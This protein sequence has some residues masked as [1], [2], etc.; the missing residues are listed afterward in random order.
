MKP[1]FSILAILLT[2]FAVHGQDERKFPRG[3]KPTPAH[4][5]AAAMKAGAITI[6]KNI[7]APPQVVYVPKRLS[8]WGNS[9]YGDCVTAESCFA[10]AAYS[11]YVG[12]DEIFV[13]EADCIAWARSHG[14]LNGADLLTVIQDMEKDGIKDEKGSVRKAGAS[15]VVDYTVE[16]SLQSAIALGPVSIAIDANAL[17]SG[18]GNKSG[19]YAF[20]GGRFPNTDHCVSLCGYGPTSAL[21][22]ALGAPVPAGAPA[23]GYYLYTWNT[24][25][26]VDHKWLMNTC[27]EAW[28]RNPTT[29]N[30][31][32]PTPTPTPNPPKPGVGKI[33]IQIPGMADQTFPFAVPGSKAISGEM[34]LKEL[35][36]LMQK[37]VEKIEPKKSSRLTP[38][39]AFIRVLCEPLATLKF[40]G[41]P[42]AIRAGAERRFETPPLDG[43]YDYDL[44]VADKF[45]VRQRAVRVWPGAEVTIDMRLSV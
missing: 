30:L 20:G 9:Q 16:S 1:L 21:F 18:A 5:V 35:F 29:T 32:S 11:T 6:H 38:V 7:A 33:I 22:A 15:A 41:E 27:V 19:W 17:P 36:D 34:T 4:K 14:W 10:I 13:T 42:T 24:I 37:P 12:L 43:A 8:M 28:V 3:A 44:Q 2:A 39:P 31:P 25:G 23:S 45:G 40:D 26:V